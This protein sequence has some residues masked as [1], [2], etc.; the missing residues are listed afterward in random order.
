MRYIEE[1]IGAPVAMFV[2]QSRGWIPFSCK[3]RSKTE[4]LATT[5]AR[6]ERRWRMADYKEL[7]CARL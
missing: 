1:L 4:V 6:S 7:P 5:P 2:H 3:T